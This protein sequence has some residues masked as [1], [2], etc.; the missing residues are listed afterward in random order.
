ME[1]IPVTYEEFSDHNS[2]PVA[3]VNG[4]AMRPIT[5]ILVDKV[6]ELIERENIRQN[7]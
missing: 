2:K 6:N 5:Q 7:K 1:K 3:K 4:M